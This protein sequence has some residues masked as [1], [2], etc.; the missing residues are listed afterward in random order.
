MSLALFRLD[1][2]SPVGPFRTGSSSSVLVSSVLASSVLASSVSSVLR[3]TFHGHCQRILVLV[4]VPGPTEVES[5]L[6]CFLYSEG[7]PS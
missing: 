7:T 6:Q 3:P 4:F 2:I 1:V 5:R